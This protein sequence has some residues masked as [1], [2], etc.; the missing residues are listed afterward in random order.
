[1]E[2]GHPP[3]VGVHPPIHPR[4]RN[5]GWNKLP[6]ELITKGALQRDASTQ[7]V[8]AFEAALLTKPPALRG[9]SD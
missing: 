2:G 8:T 7:Q 3:I 6:S 9:V 1:M 5:R 4:T